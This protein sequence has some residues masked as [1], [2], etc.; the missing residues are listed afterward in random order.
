VPATSSAKPKP[1]FDLKAVLKIPLV[2]QVA[3]TVLI[4]VAPGIAAKIGRRPLL[5]IGAVTTGL[6][7]LV[8]SGILPAK[9][10][11]PL[12]AV[13]IVVGFIVAQAPVTPVAAPVLT[14]DQAKR[15]TV[16]PAKAK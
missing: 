13:V 11:D 9:I 14:T 3:K 8:K 2:G 4:K 6:A 16:V 15:V 7:G 5:A 12:A 10:S 1:K